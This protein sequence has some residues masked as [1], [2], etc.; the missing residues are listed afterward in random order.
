MPSYRELVARARASITELNPEQVRARLGEMVLIDVRETDE[1][2]QGA[3]PGCHLLP[4]GILE[5]DIGTLAP[6]PDT[7]IVLYCGG[8]SRSALAAASLREMG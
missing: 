2:R 6:D 4:R 7:Q 5:R 3:I 8:G 1:H